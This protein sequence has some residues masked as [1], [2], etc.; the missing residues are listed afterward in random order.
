MQLNESPSENDLFAV[1]V[2]I[3][4]ALLVIQQYMYKLLSV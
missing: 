2:K 1:I 3:L 4:F